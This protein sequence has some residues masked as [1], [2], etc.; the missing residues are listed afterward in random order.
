MVAD[1]GHDSAQSEVESSLSGSPVVPEPP[2]SAD[3]LFMFYV[4]PQSRNYFLSV[5]DLAKR[6]S[7]GRGFAVL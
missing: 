7:E 1:I 5:L 3:T 2:G 4:N 6:Q